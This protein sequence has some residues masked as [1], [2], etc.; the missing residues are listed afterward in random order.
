MD[1]LYAIAIVDL[2]I[3]VGAFLFVLLSGLISRNRENGR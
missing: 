3:V 2:V 1:Y